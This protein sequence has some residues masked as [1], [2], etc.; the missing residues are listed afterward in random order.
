[1]NLS[2]DGIHATVLANRGN[3]LPYR[4]LL[5]H[6]D[7]KWNERNQTRE[8]PIPQGPQEMPSDERP[9]RLSSNHGEDSQQFKTRPKPR[10]SKDPAFSQVVSEV[11]TIRKG[12]NNFHM[13]WARQDCHCNSGGI[14]MNCVKGANLFVNPSRISR[15]RR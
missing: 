11:F 12:L 9:H 7:D 8:T 1:V 14:S 13:S 3:L 10:Y 6:K 15:R 4:Y 2:G 5:E